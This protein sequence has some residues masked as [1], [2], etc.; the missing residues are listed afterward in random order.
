MMSIV[1]AILPRAKSDK[2]AG[3]AVLA[4]VG[5]AAVFLMRA[6]EVLAQTAATPPPKQ[7]LCI[8]HL[9]KRIIQLAKLR[10]YTRALAVANE[11]QEATR[12]RFGSESTCFARALSHRASFLQLMSRPQEAAPLFE[13]TLAI[14]QRLLPA[15]HADLTLA[16]N[17]WGSNLFWQRRYAEA[18]RLHE[19]ALERRQRALPIDERAIADS[20]HNLADAYRY[21]GRPPSVV[22]S[23]Y[24]RSLQIRKKVLRPDDPAIGQS[25]QNLASVY[26]LQGDLDT[27]EQNLRAA[28]A[29]YR[30]STVPDV[31]ALAAV[32]NRL[33]GIAFRRG[34]L[35]AAERQFREAIRQ[36]KRSGAP[37]SM[38]LAAALDDLAVNQI[39]RELLDDAKALLLEALAARQKIL[40]P[41]HGSI[42]RTLSNLSEV[43]WRQQQFTRALEASR[44]ATKIAVALGRSDEAIRFGM[45]RHI[46][47]IWAALPG[48]NAA[49]N[50]VLSDEAF[51]LAQRA[52]A[53][54]L[55]RVISKMSARL[56]TSNADLGT[57]LRSD[58]ELQRDQDFLEIQLPASF[59]LPEDEQKKAFTDVRSK[60]AAIESQR[61]EIRSKV[62][63]AFPEYFRLVSPNPLNI[64]D[65]QTLLGADEALIAIYVSF[66]AVYVWTV[67]KNDAAWMQAKVGV[68]ELEAAVA[69]LR[70]GLDYK[71]RATPDAASPSDLLPF[72]L[73]VAHD[74]YGALF[75]QVEELI[76]NKHLLVI[77]TGPLTSLPFHVLVTA[78]PEQPIPMRVDDYAGAAWLARRHA[79]GMLPSV[80]SLAALRRL[81]PAMRAPNPYIGFG[82][83]LL[84]GADGEDRRAWA[85]ARCGERTQ[86]VRLATAERA[87]ARGTSGGVSKLFRGSRAEVAVVRKLEP[88]PETADELCEVAHSLGAM[89]DV[90]V[91]GAGATETAVKALSAA[92][93]LSLNRV[94]HFATHGS[95][96]GDIKGLAE[97]ALVLTPPSEDTPAT[98]LEHDDGLL[99]ASEVTQLRLNADWVVLSACNT[100]AGDGGNAEALSGLARAFFHAGARALLVSHWEVN[101]EAAVKLITRAFGAL[102]SQPG[103]GRAEALR[104]AMLATIADGGNLA[105]PEAWAPFVVVGEGAAAAR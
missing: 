100:A 30:R 15:D 22:M 18:A 90:V 41:T 32:L 78:R 26:E 37:P 55:G 35:V 60:L 66:D 1:N 59:L 83:P 50:S 45:Q 58:E 53:T 38:T 81:T 13:Q 68:R 51:V 63:R 6:N 97:P 23:L 43:A 52:Y 5:I 88:L 24:E 86:P 84:T 87:I 71:A 47:A 54:D 39:E 73:E 93:T 14:Y 89:D 61:A 75:G 33:G 65:V 48:K 31:P 103:I 3:L 46:R 17:N 19:E 27:A 72:N 67:T 40:P 102:E 80:A 20:L 28:L 16:L 62:E 7:T 92:G 76:K 29:I 82:N 79:I 95:V 85:I 8:A 56:A 70:A 12:S 91:L 44:Q 42:A 94:V 64:K 77:P 99:T 104:R 25:L 98:A 10:E 49:A 57:L 11:F 4:G 2:H 105:H 34:H 96:A 21:L 74:L 9:E 36:L 69:T 101:S